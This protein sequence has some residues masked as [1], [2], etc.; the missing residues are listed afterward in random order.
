MRVGGPSLNPHGRPP[1]PTGMTKRLLRDVQQDY[2][3]RGGVAWLHQ[4][5]NEQFAAMVRHVVPRVIQEDINISGMVSVGGVNLAGL[6][7]QELRALAQATHESFEALLAQAGIDA[8]A[9][10]A[11]FEEVEQGQDRP[12]LPAP[13]TEQAQEG[14]EVPQEVTPP[15]DGL[16]GHG[17]GGKR[18][19]GPDRD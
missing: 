16:V 11:E 1:G 5:D 4:L 8:A 10:D 15:A 7:D 2:E 3:A 13:P 6:S 12:A 9:I 19:K 17:K 14:Q 18:R